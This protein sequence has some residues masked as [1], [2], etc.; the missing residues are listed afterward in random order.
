MTHCNSFNELI[1]ILREFPL[2]D[3]ELSEKTTLKECIN[4]FGSLMLQRVRS[5]LLDHYPNSD[6]SKL[7]EN[8][9]ISEIYLMINQTN[10]I[11][12]KIYPNSPKTEEALKEFIS[13]K[14]QS[15]FKSNGIMNEVV[16]V[17][18]DIESIQSLPSNILFPSG[19]SFRSKTF[20]PSEI[21]YASTRSSPIH[22]LLGIFCAKEAIMK[23][24][25]N[26]ENLSFKDIEITH[27]STGRPLCNIRKYKNFDFKLSISHSSEYACA[28]VIMINS[29]CER[30]DKKR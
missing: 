15:I 1:S 29:F 12:D 13:Y 27:N 22:T 25:I 7:N 28:F 26:L 4:L 30:L 17:G 20:Y 21:A 3:T 11:T 6:L 18:V 9:S 23:C 10:Q 14:P 2:K 8:S 16:S 5:L 19:S 24:C